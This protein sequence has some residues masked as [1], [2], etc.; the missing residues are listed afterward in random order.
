MSRRRSSPKRSCGPGIDRCGYDDTFDHRYRSHSPKRSCGP[1]IDHSCH[2]SSY[3]VDGYIYGE[4]KHHHI[5]VEIKASYRRHHYQIAPIFSESSFVPVKE[6]TK[7][8]EEDPE[9]ERLRT[10]IKR[11]QAEIDEL[12]IK[13]P[14]KAVSICTICIVREADMITDG[15]TCIASCSDCIV[16]VKCCPICRAPFTSTKKVYFPG[17]VDK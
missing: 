12:R 11:Q 15:C 13:D 2:R 17:G 9:L 10:E 6:A 14:Q 7:P 1:D 8:K 3:G 4:D 5:P 16:G